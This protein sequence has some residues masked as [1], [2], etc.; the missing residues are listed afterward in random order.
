MCS[1]PPICDFLEVRGRW[2]PHSSYNIEW[3]SPYQKSNKGF[4]HDSIGSHKNSV[5]ISFVAIRFQGEKNVSGDAGDSRTE[6]EM[7]TLKWNRQAEIGYG[8]KSE[9]KC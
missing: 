2:R 3:D 1:I 4:R 7:F 9:E 5:W 6:R 8:R